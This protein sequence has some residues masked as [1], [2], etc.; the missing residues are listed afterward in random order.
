MLF[1]SVS[2]GQLNCA[3][4]KETSS[5]VTFSVTGHRTKTITV[6]IP[7]S[8]AR[9]LSSYQVCY[10]SSNQFRNR[11]GQLVNTGLL[12]DCAPMTSEPAPCVVSRAI[13]GG[14]V[15]VV[16]SAPLADPKGRL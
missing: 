11:N 13:G 8:S 10:N 1:F 15:V 5:L 14:D 6:A 9:P 2:P 4:Y 16:F 12:P 7:Q 3:H